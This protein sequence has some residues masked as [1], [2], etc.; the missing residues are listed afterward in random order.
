MGERD[1]NP[2]CRPTRL[3]DEPCPVCDVSGEAQRIDALGAVHHLTFARQRSRTRMPAG[4][5]YRGSECRSGY[6]LR[7]GAENGE[8]QEYSLR[9]RMILFG[10]YC[11]TV[12]YRCRIPTVVDD[13]GSPV[14]ADCWYSIEPYRRHLAGTTEKRRAA[15]CTDR[16][17][18]WLARSIYLTL[19]AG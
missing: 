3:S 2:G 9:Y 11:Q 1:E 5:C 7:M 10:A 16:T 13:T 18:C 15:R 14:T 6:S 19:S 17:V 4:R 8:I 12:L